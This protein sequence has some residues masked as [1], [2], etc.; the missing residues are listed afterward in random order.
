MKVAIFVE[1]GSDFGY[2]QEYKIVATLNAIRKDPKYWKRFTHLNL[3]SN[4]NE[5]IILVNTGGSEAVTTELLVKMY[6]K[7]G[8]RVF[9]GFN[10]STMLKFGWNE[11]FSKYPDTYVISMQSTAPSLKYLNNVFRLTPSDDRITKWYKQ[12]VVQGQYEKVIILN[13]ANDVYSNQL[14]LLLKQE[15]D[16]VMSN[17]EI[18]YDINPSNMKTTLE[19]IKNDLDKSKKTLVIPTFVSYQESYFTT[20]RDVFQ[21]NDEIWFDQLES[22]DEEPSYLI[23][24]DLVYGKYYSIKYSYIEKDNVLFHLEKDV[25]GIDNLSLLFYDALQIADSIVGGNPDVINWV[26]GTNGYLYLDKGERENDAWIMQKVDEVSKKFQFFRGYVY[27]PEFSVYA[28][29]NKIE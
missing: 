10:R 23:P 3:S 6:S 22:A 5:D 1:I 12:F 21:N 16:G 8:V 9:I 27:I 24:T 4:S 15:L 7:Y 2:K 26:I 28:E 14:S 19:K 13:Q 25:G 29:I 18:W 11:F 20:F 17:T